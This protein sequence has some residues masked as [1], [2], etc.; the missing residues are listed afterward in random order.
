MPQNKKILFISEYS[1]G[2]YEGGNNNVYR[3]A[4]ALKKRNIDVEILCSSVDRDKKIVEI[5]SIKYHLFNNK[6]T[7]RILNK[8][9]WEQAVEYGCEILRMINPDIV[10]LHHWKGLYWLIESANRLNIKS[11]YTA[12]DHGMGCLQTVLLTSSDTICN[13]NVDNRKCYSCIRKKKGWKNY[14]W[15]TLRIIV[16]PLRKI[17]NYKIFYKYIKREDLY[18]TFD[19]VFFYTANIKKVLNM[20]D[21]IIVPNDFAVVFFKQFIGN[22]VNKIIKLNWFYE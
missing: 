5:D 14:P 21:V 6:Y 17:F 3:Q 18:Y 15:I 7:N 4:F 22:N 12:H 9:E 13:G 10:H 1:F 19:D 2:K 8:E 20:L 11:L 16:L